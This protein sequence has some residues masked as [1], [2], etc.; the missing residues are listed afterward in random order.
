MVFAIKVVEKVPLI[1]DNHTSKLNCKGIMCNLLAGAAEEPCSA[2]SSLHIWHKS[3]I[4]LFLLLG[5]CSLRIG[6]DAQ[7]IAA[8]IAAAQESSNRSSSS[9]WLQIMVSDLTSQICVKVSSC[10]FKGLMRGQLCTL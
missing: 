4:A 7:V 5:E 3:P 9:K 6:Y 2:Q 8:V 1:V 10:S